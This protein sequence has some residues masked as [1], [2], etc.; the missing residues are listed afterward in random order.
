VDFNRLTIPQALFKVFGLRDENLRQIANTFVRNKLVA[1][2]KVAGVQ[3][4]AVFIRENQLATLHNAILLHAIFG[5]VKT[6]KAI[7]EDA[8]L[9]RKHAELAATVFHRRNSLL[10]VALLD[11]RALAL[12]TALGGALDLRREKLPNPFATLPQ[13][14]AE[15]R[16]GLV[17]ALLAQAGAISAGDSILLAYLQGDLALARERVL[18]T[19][20]FPEDLLDLRRC[21]LGDYQEAVDFDDLLDSL[22]PYRSR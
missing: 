7:F 13:V 6:V 14:A 17:T 21:I 10:G 1:A 19:E 15:S 16:N 5:N 4:D 8:P 12:V 2:D 22:R 11:E 20:N 9:R 3:R 18:A